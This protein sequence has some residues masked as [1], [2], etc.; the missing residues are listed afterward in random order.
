MGDT[1]RTLLLLLLLGVWLDQDQAK[2]T[3]NTGI[4]Q[5]EV[6]E[7]IPT[8]IE[9]PPEVQEE[10]DDEDEDEDGWIERHPTSTK[11]E[12]DATI[13][14]DS[15]DETDAIRAPLR[16]KKFD[17]DYV[18][19][20]PTSSPED[21][22]PG[23]CK[24]ND[25]IAEEG[26]LDCEVEGSEMTPYKKYK[27]YKNWKRRPL[28]VIII[29]GLRW[30][31]LT[32]SDWNMTQKTVG[33]MKA[34]N[35]IKK[36]GTTM[37]QVVPVYPP[38]DLPTWTSLATGL[39]PKNTGVVGD[40]MFN[41]KTRELFDREEDGE[42]LENWWTKGEP[43][44]SVAAKH[45]RKV[46]VLNW[47]DCSLPG[48]GIEKQADCKPYVAK[49]PEVEEGAPDRC[50]SNRK[51][52]ILFNR[53]FTKIQEGYDLSVVYIDVLKKA[54]KRYGPNSPEMM[55][56][57][58]K[59]DKVLQ[60][61]LSD[62]KNKK[63]RAD[64]KLNILL[65]S[66]Y[67]LNGVYNTTKVTLDDFMNFDH[68]QYIIQRGGSCVLVPYALKAGDIMRGVGGKKGVSNMIGINSY[69]RDKN[70][71]VPPLDYE[72]IPDD[73]HYDGLTWTQDIVLVA[74]PGF[75]IVIN[76]TYNPKI[77]PPVR[78]EE[79][80]QSGYE[81]LPATPYIRPGRDKHKTKEE[82]A[83]E[84]KEVELYKEFAH[85]MKT[86]GFAWGPDF[87]TGYT[88]EPIEI[89]DLYQLMAFLLQ[90]PPN[91]HEG[92]WKRVRPMLTISSAPA[93]LSSALPLMV[94]MAVLIVLKGQQY[95]S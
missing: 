57:L 22:G 14:D 72:T 59:L 76:E 63:E 24:D 74:K 15:D 1:M 43:I 42:S 73:L 9:G 16:A 69:V 41:L 62:I 12:D 82:R 23:K 61:R 31:Y 54:A 2:K 34:F 95:L 50:I 28:F 80:G 39:Y 29:G 53:A 77:L 4:K 40:Y 35:W 13:E 93:Q 65:V 11:D 37:S 68:V 17:L 27:A 18:V 92:D 32:K 78:D 45:G 48:K 8:Q 55:E 81:P 30:D 26:D 85:S 51:P 3:I 44:W 83:R 10:D 67:G 58:Q 64:L 86:I 20:R 52:S 94:L 49:C 46:S 47:H 70:L 33:S 66:D 60:S 79:L 84:K 5:H 90:V 21:D 6:F 38:Y 36:H 25:D 88:A 19:N 71:E 89:V 56:E 7:A 87:K 75:E 91:Y